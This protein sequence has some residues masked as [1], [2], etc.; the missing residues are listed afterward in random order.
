MYIKAF[1]NLRHYFGDKWVERDMS[2]ASAN[3]SSSLLFPLNRFRRMHP[4]SFLPISQANLKR[5][6]SS[7]WNIVAEYEEEN[8][9]SNLDYKD[10]YY[11]R[12]D[13]RDR[14]RM[15]SMKAPSVAVPYIIFVVPHDQRSIEGDIAE[16]RRLVV[17]FMTC[18]E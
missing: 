8:G 11:G 10:S 17:S 18:E 7:M 9:I 16:M 2:A 12:M 4:T 14:R 5:E 1:R 15:D 13:W 3:S 6:L